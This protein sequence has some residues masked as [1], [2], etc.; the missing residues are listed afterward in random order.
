MSGFVSNSVSF[1]SGLD[2]SLKTFHE[3]FEKK[4]KMLVV[5][6]MRRLIART[7]VNTGKAVINYVASVGAPYSGPQLE[8]FKAVE[9]TN[10]LPLGAEQLRGPA[11]ARPWASVARLD[12]SNPYKVYWISNNADNIAGLEYGQLPFAPFRQRSP[13]GMFGITLLELSQLL[14][15]GIL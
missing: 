6:G 3:K 1:N 4:V 9:A 7:P 14:A 10:L 11:S 13:S 12:F 15:R 8:G 2:N 5:E